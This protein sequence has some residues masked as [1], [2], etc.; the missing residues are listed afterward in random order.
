ME[1]YSQNVLAFIFIVK[2]VRALFS[3]L[4]NKHCFNYSLILVITDL[5]LT[6][7]LRWITFA[8]PVVKLSSDYI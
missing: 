7:L 1:Q 8:F 2:L 4:I 3:Q 5:C 6:P